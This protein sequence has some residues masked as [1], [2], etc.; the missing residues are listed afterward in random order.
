M[1]SSSG[2]GSMTL[3]ER[4]TEK[5]KESQD[6]PDLNRHVSERELKKIE[7][8][9]SK[10]DSLGSLKFLDVEKIDLSSVFGDG[11]NKFF[12]CGVAKLTAKN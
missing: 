7:K 10:A 4:T 1:A 9:E 8:L 6:E 11:I 12:V 2:Y 3:R 5:P